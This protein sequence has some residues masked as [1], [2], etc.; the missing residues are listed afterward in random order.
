MVLQFKFW[1]RTWLEA[2]AILSF[3]PSVAYAEARLNG[4]G[5]LREAAS[6]YD[7][8]QYFKSA[9]Y[10]FAAF[11]E[12]PSLKSDAYAWVT[13]GLMHAG[14]PNA[15]SYF[16][17]RTLQNGSP[18]AI[19]SVTSQTQ[20]LI[21]T[22]GADLLRKYL[23]RHTRYED[24]DDRNRSAYLYALAKD[25][26]VSGDPR[27]AIGYLNGISSSSSLWPFAM[28]LRG[29]AFALSGQDIHAIE[30]FKTCE[31][32]AGRIVGREGDSSDIL[33]RSERESEDLRARCIAGRARTLYQM[34]QFEDADRVYDRI[35]RKSFVWPDILF[36]QGWNSFAKTEY[37][38]SLGKLV[39]YK[40]PSL[41]F[42]FNTEVDV[43]RSQSYLALCLYSDANHVINEFNQ[44]YNSV[45]IEVK[46]FVERNSSNLGSFYDLGKTVLSSSLSTKNDF[47]RLINRFVRSPYFQNLVLNEKQV[48]SEMAAIRRFDLGQPGV[49]HHLNQGFPGFLEEV[50]RWRLQSI[51]LLGGAFVKN[52]LMDYHSVLIND[53]EKMAFIKLEMLKKAKDKLI[54]KNSTSNERSR[55]NQIPSRRDDQYRWS[56]NGEFWADE[57]GD[58]VFGLES[59][60][61]G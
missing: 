27:R 25:A 38:R 42:V 26:L 6:L 13:M 47:Y 4:V 12:D 16:F 1:H 15:S 36:E 14:L 2:L 19:R 49:S 60:C 57:L 5:Y 43:L 34:N 41:G 58:Y 10:A 30:D 3:L 33:I 50:L 17:I 24:Y 11:E 23:I 37:N 40:S 59:E 53:F 54:Y 9:R 52:S 46:S 7:Q 39:S 48:A 32:N 56:F 55:G 45:G 21:M 51:R 8:G 44:K 20:D 28:H 31:N 18:K 35:Q 22:V 61:K 29:S